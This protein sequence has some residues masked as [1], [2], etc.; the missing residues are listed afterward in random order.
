MTCRRFARSSGQLACIKAAS[1]DS[2]CQPALPAPLPSTRCAAQDAQDKKKSIVCLTPGPSLL[3]SR[4]YLSHV[5]ALAALDGAEAREVI[6]RAL[7][8]LEADAGVALAAAHG[9]RHPLLF[10]LLGPWPTHG[11]GAIGHEIELPDLTDAVEVH[12]LLGK[13][14]LAIPAVLLRD[15]ICLPRQHPVV[16]LL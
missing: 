9:V 5:V 12:A 8:G 1:L 10:T 4:S 13:E 11:A 2:Y 7:Q 16:A 6:L 15:Q 3:H 14:V